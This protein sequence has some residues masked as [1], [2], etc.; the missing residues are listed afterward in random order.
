MNSDERYM[1]S[2]RRDERRSRSRDNDSKRR[3][4]RER[5]RK[6]KRRR[7]SRERYDESYDYPH[8]KKSIESLNEVIEKHPTRLEHHTDQLKKLVSILEGKHVEPKPDFLE[9]QIALKCAFKSICRYVDSTPVNSKERNLMTGLFKTVQEVCP[10]HLRTKT[11]DSLVQVEE[12]LRGLQPGFLNTTQSE[13]I[14]HTINLI[15]QFKG[16]GK[17]FEESQRN[18]RI[19]CL[20]IRKMHDECENPKEKNRIAAFSNGLE[21]CMKHL[22]SDKLKVKPVDTMEE[23]LTLLKIVDPD[24]VSAKYKGCFDHSVRNLEIFMNKNEE[25]KLQKKKPK[26][27][28]FGHSYNP[29]YPRY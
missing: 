3:R 15:Q 24:F 9:S 5:D 16:K 28:W 27:R 21:K 10:R 14:Q 22:T 8:I 23:V 20:S 13:R 17:E 12:L 29:Y 2:S 25:A 11:V 6:R 19:A 1:P 26:R 4:S 18:L 7:D